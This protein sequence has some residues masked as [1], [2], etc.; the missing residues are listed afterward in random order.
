MRAGDKGAP[1]DA[2]PEPE[3]IVVG[4]GFGG[5]DSGIAPSTH[6]EMYWQNRHFDLDVYRYT[7]GAPAAS[8][9]VVLSEEVS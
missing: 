1:V 7:V 4:A 5:I 2:R 8:E 6:G 3:V 9:A